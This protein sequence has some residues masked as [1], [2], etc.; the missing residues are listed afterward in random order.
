MTDEDERGRFQRP[1]GRYETY[2]RARLAQVA[3]RLERAIYPDTAPVS[4]IEIAGPTGRIGFEAAQSLDYRPVSLG[5]PLGP[6]W[7]T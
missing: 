1:R 2:T 6:L 4:R 3:R 5:E 7:S